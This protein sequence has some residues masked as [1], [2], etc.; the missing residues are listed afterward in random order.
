[1]KVIADLYGSEFLCGTVGLFTSKASKSRDV[2]QC[3]KTGKMYLSGFAPEG[4][5]GAQ[6]GVCVRSTGGI[7]ELAN[8]SLLANISKAIQAAFV[9]GLAK[10]AAAQ[11]Q[12]LKE[13]TIAEL[14]RQ[15]GGTFAALAAAGLNGGGGAQQMGHAV[16]S[17]AAP[18]S[19][20]GGMQQAPRMAGGLGAA[21][22]GGG[23]V[24]PAG[25]LGDGAMVTAFANSAVAPGDARG[26]AG[27]AASG[28][29]DGSGAQQMGV[30]GSGDMHQVL[31]LELLLQYGMPL[32]RAM[33][34][35]EQYQSQRLTQLLENQS[36]LHQLNDQRS[37]MTSLQMQ[38]GLLGV[39]SNINLNLA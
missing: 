15:Y 7:L 13:D 33:Q 3:F 4:V 5:N 28:L 6:V 17:A 34:C 25:A 26:S 23:D 2:G 14:G 18:D 39:Q 21:T 37:G 11:K 32:E 38:Q 35:N 9:D 10:K 12:Q 1:M 20:G 22:H 19:G 16:N 29:S 31:L 36:Q 27:G 30:D 8:P 24:P